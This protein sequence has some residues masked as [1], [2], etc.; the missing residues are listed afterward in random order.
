MATMRGFLHQA[1][2]ACIGLHSGEGGIRTRGEASPTPVFET[3]PFGRSGTSP[4]HTNH[5]YSESYVIGAALSKRFAL[6][7]TARSDVAES[8][9]GKI[10]IMAISGQ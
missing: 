3:G 8:G 9:F 5:W 6:P 4:D 2:R 1:A 7:F 10:N